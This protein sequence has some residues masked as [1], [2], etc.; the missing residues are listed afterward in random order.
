MT[1]L[2]VAEGFVAQLAR[3]YLPDAP[4]DIRMRPAPDGRSQII[5]NCTGLL[6][7]IQRRLVPQLEGLDRT[8]LYAE[9]VA[10]NDSQAQRVHF[11]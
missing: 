7:G 2:C 4:L 11:G 1:R 10:I 9:N 3:D 8:C 5:A 6:P